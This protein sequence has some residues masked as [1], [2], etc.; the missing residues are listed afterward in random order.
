MECEYPERERERERKENCDVMIGVRLSIG[1][2][3]CERSPPQGNDF[4]SIF[5]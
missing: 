1:E 2:T 5:T 3:D 4:I